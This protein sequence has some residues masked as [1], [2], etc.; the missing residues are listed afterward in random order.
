MIKNV[1][2]DRDGI[3]N[4]VIIRNAKVESPRK[5]QEFNLKNEFIDFYNSFN[6]KDILFFVVS[7]Q[8]DISRKLMNKR[9]LLL[10]NDVM[11][12]VFKF[13]EIVY[14]MHDDKDKC[15]CRKPKPGMINSLI[16]KYK[17]K[18][19]ECVIIGDSI[20]DIK[21]GINAGIN[22]IF[23]KQSYNN[24]LIVEADFEV[25][26]LTEILNLEIWN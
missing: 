6:E 23:L 15:N 22:T 9:D 8:P 1:F 12:S 7:N 3:I 18:K 4:D 16:A 20:K 14:C 2:L 25:K 13:K 5:I 11:K 17:L 24:A 10:M 26:K 21:S 19:S